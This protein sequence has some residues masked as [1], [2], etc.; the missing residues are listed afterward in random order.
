MQVQPEQIKRQQMILQALGFY[1]GKLDGI[2]GPMTIEAKK[3]FEASPNFRP[4]IPNNGL[5]FGDRPPYPAGIT[6][7]H[8]T[9]L[10]H[11]PSIDKHLIPAEPVVDA[12]PTE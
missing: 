5:P 4:G 2:W 8:T 7:D 1:H 11:H 9:G 3:R 10:L 6:M 12:D